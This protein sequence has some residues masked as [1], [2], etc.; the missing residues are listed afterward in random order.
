MNKKSIFIRYE[1]F[2]IENNQKVTNV[3][4]INPNNIC[5][6]ISD[7]RFRSSQVIDTIFYYYQHNPNSE[8]MI[9]IESIEST[10]DNNYI[11]PT[12]VAYHPDDWTDTKHNKS[13]FEYLPVTYLKD[14]QD[15]KALLLIDQSV[16]GYHTVWLWDWFYKKCQEYN[17]DPSS[18]IYLTGDQSSTD[19]YS[20]WCKINNPIDRLKVIP[21]TSLA[22]YIHRHYITN[23]LNINFDELLEYKKTNN[24]NI[25]LYDCINLRPR[26]QRILNFLHLLNAGLLE[27]GNISMSSYK[28]WRSHFTINSTFLKRYNLSIEILSKLDDCTPK[29]TLHTDLIGKDRHYYVYVERILDEMYK[30]SWV[31][32]VVES[33]YFKRENAVFI[34]EK[35]FKPIACMQPFIIVGSKGTLKYLRKLGYKTFHPY[36]DESYDELDDDERFASVIESIKKIQSI[37]DKVS[38][39]QSIRDIVEHNHRLFLSIGTKKSYEHLEIVKYYLDYFKE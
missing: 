19:S 10:N 30:N 33:S 20:D 39:Y 5:N 36:I 4:G 28:E 31:S 29:K 11:I 21:S 18:I 12:A 14:M 13:I 8:E 9:N 2:I 17:L 35:T 37:E 25:F 16:E 27:F 1:K 38:W 15:K 34:S 32:I 7:K 23:N 3:D 24:N 26:P 6:F 22:M